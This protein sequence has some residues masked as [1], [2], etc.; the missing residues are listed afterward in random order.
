MMMEG[1]L[2]DKIFVIQKGAKKKFFYE[3]CCS[4]LSV[5]RDKNGYFKYRYQMPPSLVMKT[6]WENR[7]TPNVSLDEKLVQLESFKHNSPVH[8]II[9]RTMY[10]FPNTLFLN[11]NA[12]LYEVKEPDNRTATGESRKRLGL[13]E[14]LNMPDKER[15][16]GLALGVIACYFDKLLK[17]SE[18]VYKENVYHFRIQ[19][20]K[21]MEIDLFLPE[22]NMFMKTIKTDRIT[23]Y[24]KVKSGKIYGFLCNYALTY[25]YKE[26]N[27]FVY[28]Y[29]EKAPFL[30]IHPIT[31]ITNEDSD[32]SIRQ[33][34]STINFVP[35][36]APL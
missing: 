5:K 12:N 3:P 35:D 31:E 9:R 17:D 18:N 25:A 32:D 20:K 8:T 16:K 24:P 27:P 2:S 22:E 11:D 34:L 23:E 15:A 19:K 33:K 36:I 29:I 6:L 1:K 28:S 30:L 7:N 21:N 26:Q 10:G 4:T 14:L 13:F